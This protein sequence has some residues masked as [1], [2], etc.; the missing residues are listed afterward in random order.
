MHHV[1][2]APGQALAPAQQHLGVGRARQAG[3]QG[4]GVGVAPEERR[5]DAQ[6]P[7]RHLVGQQPH[8][9]TRLERLHQLAHARQRGGCR[10]QAGPLARMVHQLAQPRLPRGAEQHCHGSIGAEA[11]GI[12]LG[13]DLE[14]AQ[15]RREEQQP[16][17]GGHRD[18]D[19]LDAVPAHR[20]RRAQPE[21]RQFGH[22]FARLGH[23]PP[24]HAGRHAGLAGVGHQ[25]PPV[26]RRQ[27]EAQPAQQQPCA[28]QH[29]QWQAAAECEEKT[30]QRGQGGVP[31]RPA[32]LESPDRRVDE[33]IAGR[34]TNTAKAFA[35]F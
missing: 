33:L 14:T 18:L 6:A 16:A 13:G 23:R 31:A 26:A 11:G 9:F 5:P 1:A 20:H 24:G 4:H 2:L 12:G 28:V 8:G 27:Q 22:E 10:A 21:P 3:R 17:P 25:A 34:F 35:D 30:D 15:V 19:V 7:G 32:A 29:G